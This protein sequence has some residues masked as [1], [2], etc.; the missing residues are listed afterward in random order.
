MTGETPEVRSDKRKQREKTEKQREK[1][2]KRREKR[3]KKREK[4]RKERYTQDV[5]AD[6]LETI[7]ILAEMLK[8]S[9]SWC[10]YHDL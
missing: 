2:E 10:I 5:L 3:K 9:K 4:E 6:M 1:R 8:I 7:E